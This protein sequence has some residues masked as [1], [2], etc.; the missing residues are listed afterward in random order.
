VNGK[1]HHHDSGC[2]FS[3][4]ASEPGNN[5]AQIGTCAIMALAIKPAPPFSEQIE[6]MRGNPI[7]TNANIV[8]VLLF[9]FLRFY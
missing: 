6:L 8:V 2:L 9:Y 1:F 3:D 5:Q 4:Q 7:L